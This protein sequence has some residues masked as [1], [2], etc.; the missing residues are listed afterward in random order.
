MTAVGRAVLIF[1]LLEYAGKHMV[2]HK[3]ALDF[4]I[5][6]QNEL[7]KKYNGKTLILANSVILDVRDSF[8]EAYVFALK[9]YGIGNFSLQEV[10]PGSGSYTAYIATPGIQFGVA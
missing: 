4:Y 9:T 1:M 6:N 10:S 3:I 5:K 7:V 2:D 8:Q